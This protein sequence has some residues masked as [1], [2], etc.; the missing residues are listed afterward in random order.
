MITFV[1]IMLSISIT[2]LAWTGLRQNKV[3][4]ELN[5]RVT[6]LEVWNIEHGWLISGGPGWKEEDDGT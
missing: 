6:R 2:L 5:Q 3:L 4:G 1:L